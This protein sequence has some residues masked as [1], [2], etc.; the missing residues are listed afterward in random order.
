M[1][2]DP[3]RRTKQVERDEQTLRHSTIV[4]YESFL[5]TFPSRNS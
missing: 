1:A 4:Q 2:A 3:N 5:I